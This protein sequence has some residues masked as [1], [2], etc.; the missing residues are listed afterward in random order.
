MGA[1]N[2]CLTSLIRVSQNSHQGGLGHSKSNSAHIITFTKTLA[3]NNLFF[4]LFLHFTCT[5]THTSRLA[6]K[7]HT[8]SETK[9]AGGELLSKH[10][11]KCS[12][13]QWSPKEKTPL[14][15]PTQVPKYQLKY[16]REGTVQF[17][18]ALLNLNAHRFVFSTLLRQMSLKPKFWSAQAFCPN[19]FT[20]TLAMPSLEKW[21]TKK[22]WNVKSWDFSF[23]FPHDHV[24]RLASKCTALKVDLLQAQKTE[25]CRHVRA[26]SCP[27]LDRLGRQRG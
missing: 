9:C 1:W 5:Q 26:L 4:V 6:Q 3:S 7:C 19:H 21:M 24:K 16:E 23:P 8:W 14:G 20:A 15:K 2:G 18:Q 13:K 25:V 17:L 22:V 12:L 10:K 27:E 11:Q